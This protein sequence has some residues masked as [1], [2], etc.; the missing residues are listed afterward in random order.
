MGATV[1]GRDLGPRVSSALTSGLTS[2]CTQLEIGTHEDK[3]NGI[4][5]EN[6]LYQICLLYT[7][8]YRT[9]LHG[10]RRNIGILRHGQY[11]QGYKSGHHE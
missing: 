8:I 11:I 1:I 5:Y 3:K 9:D 2:D 10:R 6:L 4:T 7:S